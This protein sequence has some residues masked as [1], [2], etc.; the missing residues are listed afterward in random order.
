VVEGR[1]EIRE[2]TL[3][4]AFDQHNRDARSIGGEGCTLDEFLKYIKDESEELWIQFIR[5]KA[6]HD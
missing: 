1:T 4:D 2:F 5:K 6:F 3:M